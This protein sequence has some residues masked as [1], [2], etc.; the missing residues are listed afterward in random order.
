M[1]NLHSTL[2]SPYSLENAYVYLSV[3][4]IH[5]NFHVVSSANGLNEMSRNVDLLDWPS[6]R[7]AERRPFC[8]G[9]MK[10]EAPLQLKITENAMKT[11]SIK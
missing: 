6:P 9:T 11:T 8:F 7:S 4:H 1:I 5:I 3:H 10:T 2:T